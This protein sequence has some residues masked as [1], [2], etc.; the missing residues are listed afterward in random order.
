MRITNIQ[1]TN[2]ELT[3]PIREY[4]TEKVESLDRFTKR[5]DPCDVAIE[6]GKT[7]DRHNKGDIFFAEIMVTIPGDVIRTHVEKDDLYAAIDE[8]K[9]DAKRKII[10]KKEIIVDARTDVLA[11]SVIDEV[12]GDDEDDEEEEEELDDDDSQE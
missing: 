10:E 2:I 1:G 3:D 12:I 11:D 4:V 7:S 9:D 5:F 6:V 8:A